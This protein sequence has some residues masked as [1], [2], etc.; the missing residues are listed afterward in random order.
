MTSHLHS[1]RGRLGLLF[2]VILIALLLPTFAASQDQPT[3]KVEIFGGY[4]YFNACSN[5]HAIRPGAVLPLNICLEPNKFGLGTAATFNLNRWFGIT[6][7]ASGHWTNGEKGVSSLHESRFYNFSVGPKLTYRRN[8]F[9]PFVEAMVGYHRLTTETFGDAGGLGFVGGGGLDIPFTKHFGIRLAQADYVMSNHQFGRSGTVPLT[10]IRGLR[11]QTG[12]IFMFGGGEAA[13]K[14]PAAATCSGQPAEVMAGE[15]VKVTL[16]ASNFNPK[17]T[18]S[19]KWTATGGKVSGTDTNATVDTT[20]LA[21]GSYTV[22]GNVTDNG[23]GK[24]QMMASCSSSFTVKELPK[25]PPT[26][27]CSANPTTVKSGDPSTITCQGASEDNRPLTYTWKSD[28]GRISGTGTT[29]TL[30]TAGLPAGPVSITTTVGDDRELTASATTAVTVEV[31]PP[32]PTSSK[33]NEVA[34][35]DTKKPARI[36]NAAKAILDDVALR[37]QREADAKA[38]VVGKAS[39]DETKKKSNK[40][41]AA[42]RAYNAKQYL[43]NDKGID[44]SRIEV[45]TSTADESKAEVWLVPTGASFTGEGTTVVDETTMAK[46]AKPAKKAAKKKAAK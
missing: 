11:L 12:V 38:V 27:T 44:A 4:S 46:P 21:P 35:P 26:I 29:A 40:N 42:W 30:D 34:F 22:N 16:T 3:P 6:F 37:L 23:K 2:L 1:H 17:R 18:L 7:D 28:T 13:A 39:A 33:I 43:V 9:A 36:D 41:L 24:K 15:P 19:Y 25:H 20:G 14:A 8:H 45:R 10:R 31:P 5:L 32:P